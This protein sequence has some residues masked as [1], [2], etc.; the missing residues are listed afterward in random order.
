MIV[1]ELHYSINP[2]RTGGGAFK[3]PPVG[4]FLII[5][6]LQKQLNWNSGAITKHL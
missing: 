5:F 3:A 1:I 4:F 2:I 6:F